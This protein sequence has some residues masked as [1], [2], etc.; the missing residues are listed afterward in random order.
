[1]SASSRVIHVEIDGR[2]RRIELSAGEDTGE[3]RA[4]LDG[5]PIHLNAQLL[6]PGVLSLLIENRSHRCILDPH[7]AEPAVQVEG[8]SFPYRIEDPRSLSSRRARSAVSGGAQL[9]KAPMPGR[10]VRL[11]VERGDAVEAHQAIVVVE[12]MKMQNEIKASR[13]GTVTEV[14]V[15]ANATVAAGEV[16]AV[17]Q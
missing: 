14:S 6:Q 1:M 7:S 17:I 5:D 9:I 2:L 3:Y 11:M 13:P 15:A 16:L 10:V 12:A 4:T 8:H